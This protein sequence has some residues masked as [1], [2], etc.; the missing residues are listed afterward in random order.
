MIRRLS[1]WRSTFADY[2]VGSVIV[3]VHMLTAER[4]IGDAVSAANR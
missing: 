1:H 4:R 2:T 3:M